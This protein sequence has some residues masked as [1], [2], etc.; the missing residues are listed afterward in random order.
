M[1]GP[2]IPAQALTLLRPLA[3]AA[4]REG[5]PLYAVGGCVRD[6]LLGRADVK[7]LDL[8]TEGD[9]AGLARL[10]A[11]SLGGRAEAFGAFK[12]LRVMGKDWR[13]DLA[14][15]RQEVYPEPACLPKVKPAPL[16]RDLFRRDFTINAMAVRLRPEGAGELVDPYCAA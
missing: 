9:P 2:R 7:D 15:S 10:C 3:R 12:T 13:V 6:W 16:A 11:R 1:T 14:A 4:R 5:L 8:V